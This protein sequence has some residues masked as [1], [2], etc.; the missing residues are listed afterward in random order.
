MTTTNLPTTCVLSWNPLDSRKTH[1]HHEEPSHVLSASEP[2]M[3]MHCYMV[4]YLDPHTYSKVVGNPLWKETLQEE[5]ESLLEN[6]TWD[7]VPLPLGRNIFKCRWAQRIKRYK[8]RH[9]SKGLDHI[10]KY[11]YIFTNIFSEIKFQNLWD[12]L[13]VKNTVT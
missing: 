3:S 7:L 6:Q 10:H 12:R 11:F 9:D 4:Q 1:S 5:Y 2:M 13:G 8:V